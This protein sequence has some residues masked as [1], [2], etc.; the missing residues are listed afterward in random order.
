MAITQYSELKTAIANW[1]ERSDLTNRIPE[2][3]SLAQAKMYR[4]E[5]SLNPPYRWVRKPLRVN[6]MLTTGSLTPSSGSADISTL[7]RFL[8]IERIYV[9]TTP[10]RRLE[11]LTPTDFWSRNAAYESANPCFF[12]IEGNTIYIGPRS[13][14]A[15]VIGYYQTFAA[16]SD[17]ADTDWVLTNAPHVYLHGALMEAH[18][19]EKDYEARDRQAELFNAAIN[20]LDASDEEDATSAPLIMRPSAV[21]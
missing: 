2:F 12:T 11:Y 4:G 3:I 15:L 5:K 6:A 13:T 17:D 9:N 21:A 8:A 10:G 16:L 19:Y 1:L 18:E 14:T 20:G 7:T